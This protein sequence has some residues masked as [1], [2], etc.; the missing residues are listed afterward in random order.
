MKIKLFNLDITIE[1]N[2]KTWQQQ[3]IKKATA[4]AKNEGINLTGSDRLGK[5]ISRIK[6]IRL[7]RFPYPPDSDYC[8]VEYV[9]DSGMSSLSVAKQ[10]VED[11]WLDK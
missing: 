6:A 1:R 4:L 10:F 7:V 3:L 9:N 2:N 8:D 11:F 5:K